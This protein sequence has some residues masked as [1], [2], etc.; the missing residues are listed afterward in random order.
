MKKS[1]DNSMNRTRDHK[2]LKGIIIGVLGALILFL[3]FYF[4]IG[5]RNSGD[6]ILIGKEEVVFNLKDVHKSVDKDFSGGTVPIYDNSFCMKK[7][8]QKYNKIVDQCEI[9]SIKTFSR[10][11]PLV[12]D[13]N[14]VCF[15]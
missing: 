6:K 2:F 5:V 3:L 9:R 14:C 13:V 7:Y 11:N 8:E 15:E 4:L 10:L 12:I 1:V